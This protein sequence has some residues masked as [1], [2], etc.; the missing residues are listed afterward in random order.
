MEEIE[1]LI[2]AQSTT[3]PAAVAVAAE[4]ADNEDDELFEEE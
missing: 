1:R 3:A 2:R 4:G